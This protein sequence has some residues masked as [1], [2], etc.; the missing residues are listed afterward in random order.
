MAHIISTRQAASTEDSCDPESSAQ[1]LQGLR[2][3]M[4]VQELDAYVVTSEAGACGSN[5]SMRFEI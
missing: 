5:G 4:K 3:L 1:R 2:A